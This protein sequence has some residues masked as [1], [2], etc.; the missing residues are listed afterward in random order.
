MAVM[1]WLA[2]DAEQYDHHH[3]FEATAA[4][5]V[6]PLA[7]ATVAVPIPPA[8]AIAAD[9]ILVGMTAVPILAAVVLAVVAFALVPRIVDP[10][11]SEE[12]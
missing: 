1:T 3:Q 5:T 10:M 4:G 6:P 7:V 11:S 12:S 9:S 2:K 8:T